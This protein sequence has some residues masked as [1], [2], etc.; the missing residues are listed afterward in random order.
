MRTKE[1]DN[2]RIADLAMRAFWKHGYAATSIQDL[3]ECTGLSRS[4]LYSTFESKHGLYQEALRRYETVTMENVELLSTDGSPKALIRL[5]LMKVVENEISPTNQSGCFVANAALEMAGHDETIA[6]LVAHN[7]RKLQLALE[8]LI[9]RGQQSGDITNANDPSI[10]A[11]YI[12]NNLQGLRVISKGYP[13]KQR[14]EC[15]QNIVDVVIETL[16]AV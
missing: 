14:K 3:V 1:F 9:T 11:S 10:L 5:L 12:I 7:F 4:S 8:K 6:Q 2:E 15:L 13:L 16:E